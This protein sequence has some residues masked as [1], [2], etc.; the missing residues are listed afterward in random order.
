MKR[1]VMTAAFVLV[2]ALM[3]AAPVIPVVGSPGA[4]WQTLGTAV[5][6]ATV[7][8]ATA[9]NGTR[10]NDYWAGYSYDRADG[11]A[12]STACSAG[13]LVL[14][15]PCDYKLNGTSGMRQPVKPAAPGD[16]VFY[17]GFAPGTGSD[18][19]YNAD[20][21]FYLSGLIV[22]DLQVL[23]E[24]TAWKD[25]VEIGWYVKDDP[26]ATTALIGGPGGIPKDEHGNYDLG[27]AV[28]V[29]LDGEYGFYYK[30]YA[31]G[32]AYYTQS[33]LNHI[34]APSSSLLP[35]LGAFGL[36]MDDEFPL[37]MFNPAL[38]QQWALFGVGDR[39]WLGLEDIFGP[40]TP[41]TPGIPCS[42]YDYNDFLIGGTLLPPPPP[43]EGDVPEP[44]TMTLLAAGLF[45][46]ALA[47]RR[48]RV[49]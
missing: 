33:E 12:G 3:H 4:G 34:F 7:D 23:S 1:Y 17:W 49:R 27:E 20:Q 18:P 25:G 21:S 10:N 41:C 15:Y 14:G 2:P 38:Y 46:S 39:F 42:D 6:P 8:P 47:V 19:N 26:T 5:D 32:T 31:T 44:T 11:S 37:A 28:T 45:G 40:T 36:Q 35:Y 43:P 9:P 16:E 30:N 29:L 24:M 48:R 13:A 22:L